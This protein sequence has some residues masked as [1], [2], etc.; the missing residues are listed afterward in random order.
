METWE[1]RIRILSDVESSRG[2]IGQTWPA[3]LLVSDQPTAAPAPSQLN[4]Q[5]VHPF[6]N[7]YFLPMGT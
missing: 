2:F 7:V 4:I 1:H 6:E 3:E 5:I